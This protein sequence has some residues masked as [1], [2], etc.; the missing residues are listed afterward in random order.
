MYKIHNINSNKVYLLTIKRTKKNNSKSIAKVHQDQM[1]T[2]FVCI[3]F[4]VVVVAAAI[5]C[6][7]TKRGNFIKFFI[8]THK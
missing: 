7:V 5:L 6:F 3:L 2:V 8:Y 1:L 4:V